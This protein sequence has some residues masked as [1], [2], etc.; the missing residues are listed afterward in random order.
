MGASSKTTSTKANKKTSSKNRSQASSKASSK[1]TSTKANKK[2]SSK[3]RRKGYHCRTRT[4]HR[5]K[6]RSFSMSNLPS[7]GKT[8]TS[9]FYGSCFRLLI[10]KQPTTTAAGYQV[11]SHSYT[12][13]AHRS[14]TT[15]KL[16]YRSPNR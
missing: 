2:T 10:N 16:L 14:K 3:T 4:Y 7:N 15:T 9:I 8:S 5:A 11:A 1:T 12:E 13:G 6:A